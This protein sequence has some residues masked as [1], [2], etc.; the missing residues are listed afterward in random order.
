MPQ[1]RPGDHDEICEAARKYL[2]LYESIQSHR[3]NEP[4]NREDLHYLA[5]KLRR[6][7]EDNIQDA[8]RSYE[9]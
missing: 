6:K 8:A 7:I 4:D 1:L 9:Y 3:L 2:A 5:D